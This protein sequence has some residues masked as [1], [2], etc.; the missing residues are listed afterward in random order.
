LAGGGAQNNKRAGLAGGG[1]QN[2]NQTGIHS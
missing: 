1:A 2:K